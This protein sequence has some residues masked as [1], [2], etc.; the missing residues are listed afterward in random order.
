MNE[1]PELDRQELRKFAFS[2][3]A[4]LVFL[5]ILLLPGLFGFE[6]PLWPWLVALVLVCWGLV[7][8]QSLDVVYRTWM[9][10]GL[11]MGRLTTPLL[12]GILFFLVI[13]PLA[14]L[15]KLFR[16]LNMELGFDRESSS[17]RIVSSLREK[18]DMEKPF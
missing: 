11:L 16:K 3:A 1:I 13:T 10:F 17:Y 5:F 7:S 6:R 9:R 8:P 2:T 14:Y 4:I 12:L 15:M 18:Q